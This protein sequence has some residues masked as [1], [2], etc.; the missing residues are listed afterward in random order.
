MD[1]MERPPKK[2]GSLV[3]S[4]PLVAI[5]GESKNG[6]IFERFYGELRALANYH[7]S[8]E[9]ADHTL[10]PTALVHEAYLRLFHQSAAPGA[11][12]IKFLSIAS[13]MIRRILVD[14]AR[15][16]N[17]VK[18]GGK[19]QWTALSEGIVADAN[20]APLDVL[21]LDVALKKL[22]SLNSRQA[23]VVELRFF[24]GLS[25][26]ETAEA[27]DISQGSVKGDWRLAR[28]WLRVQ[29]NR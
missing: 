6:R 15:T 9:R 1:H 25:V 11:D 5:A 22:A 13:D 3:G 14:H 28:A 27:L 18:R 16:R 26:A 21:D 2:N 12:R 19:R 4:G 24:A 23:R 17:A 10:Q 20:D 7:L 29:L 8:R